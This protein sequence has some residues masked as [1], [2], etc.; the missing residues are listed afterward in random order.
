M[1][2]CRRAAEVS[3]FLVMDVLEAAQRLEREG[4]RV[5]HLEIGEPDFDTPQCIKD[6]ACRALAENKTHYTH[7]LGIIELREAIC[8][9]YQERY[10]VCLDPD[11]ILVTSGTSPAMWL[12]F[13][14]LLEEGDEVIVS[15]PCYACYKNFIGFTGAVAR[16]V[17]VTEA[18]TSS[19]TFARSAWG[20]PLPCLTMCP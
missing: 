16:P 5:V 11:Q 8:A 4:H 10:G 14:A 15:D 13:S 7:S 19:I 2:V 1:S 6:A 9:R 20:S 12:L 17:P 18:G 3:P